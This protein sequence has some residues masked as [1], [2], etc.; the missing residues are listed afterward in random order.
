MS[1]TSDKQVA[2]ISGVCGILGVVLGVALQ[3]WLLGP[4]PQGAAFK[5][6]P[7][8]GIAMREDVA[9]AVTNLSPTS[10]GIL[11][12]LNETGT[13]QLPERTWLN[14][15]QEQTAQLRDRELIDVTEMKRDGERVFSMTFT[16][17][18]RDASNAVLDFI[19]LSLM[20]PRVQ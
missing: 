12:R 18:G 2:L 5:L 13:Q 3:Y 8:A 7:R 14:T 15:Y 16:S 1:A 11:L 6:L 9:S 4:Q 19:R 17:L 10:V 20:D